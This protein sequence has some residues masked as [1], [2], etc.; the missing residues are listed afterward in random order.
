VESIRRKVFTLPRTTQTNNQ[1]N[2]RTN[3][4]M[5]YVD[6]AAVVQARG[7][8]VRAIEESRPSALRP[9][10]ILINCSIELGHRVQLQVQPVK[11]F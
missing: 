4:D 11:Y 6:P 9:Q 2:T 5:S 3:T 7:R 10:V 1:T 8:I